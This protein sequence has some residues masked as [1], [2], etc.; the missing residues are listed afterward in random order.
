MTWAATGVMGLALLAWVV[1]FC[2]G[3]RQKGREYR[4]KKSG[5]GLFGRRKGSPEVEYA[6]S[7]RSDGR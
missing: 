5:G 2:V 4:E 7:V 3:K 6:R 1:E